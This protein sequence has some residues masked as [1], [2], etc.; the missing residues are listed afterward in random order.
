MVKL[1]KKNKKSMGRDEQTNTKNKKQNKK[2]PG[3]GTIEFQ[4]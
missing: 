2:I 4:S 3:S 1:T